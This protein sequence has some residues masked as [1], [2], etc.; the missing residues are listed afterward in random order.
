MFGRPKKLRHE[1]HTSFENRQETALGTPDKLV[2]VED[3]VV[4]TLQAKG[5]LIH[6]VKFHC[7]WEQKSVET[8]SPQTRG[9]H[10]VR[11]FGLSIPCGIGAAITV[12]R[13]FCDR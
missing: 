1:T 6:D 10:R 8:A 2:G 12:H 5:V 13:T 3:V 11:A 7:L 9:I 4:E